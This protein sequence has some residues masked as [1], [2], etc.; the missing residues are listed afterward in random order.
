MD[1]QKCG[2]LIFWSQY[3]VELERCYRLMY[4]FVIIG[5][6]HSVIF[7]KQ[8]GS[9]P[10]VSIKQVTYGDYVTLYYQL[11]ETIQVASESYSINKLQ[12][13]FPRGENFLS[14]LLHTISLDDIHQITKLVHLY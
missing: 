2:K 7:N 5:L 13:T 14:R 3:L 9:F 6:K 4:K 12:D 8:M 10:D 1:F 11:W